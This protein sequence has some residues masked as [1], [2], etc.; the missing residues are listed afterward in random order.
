MFLNWKI[1]WQPEVCCGTTIDK[2]RDLDPNAKRNYRPVS[3]L[4]FLSKV[5]EKF[6]SK[7]Y[8][9]LESN[10]NQPI[11][12]VIVPKQHYWK[13]SIILFIALTVIM[14]LYLSYKKSYKFVRSV[15]GMLPLGKF[16]IKWCILK[17]NLVKF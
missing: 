6:T 13:S 1:S 14:A 3:N 2:N 5:I 17:C 16:F 10:I 7:L 12:L 15:R 9:H 8:H 11:R 4:S